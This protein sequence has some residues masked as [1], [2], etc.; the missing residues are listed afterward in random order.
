MTTSNETKEISYVTVI[1]WNGVSPSTELLSGATR[2]TWT[3]SGVHTIT[4]SHVD[5]SSQKIAGN[6]EIR[7]TRYDGTVYEFYGA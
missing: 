6:G 7:V 3:G 4:V 2:W 1:N 5:G